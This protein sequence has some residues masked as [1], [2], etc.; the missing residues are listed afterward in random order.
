MKRW[1]VAFLALLLCVVCLQGCLPNNSGAAQSPGTTTTPTAPPEYPVSVEGIT[2][3]QTP[4]RVVVMTPAIADAVKDLGFTA[5]VCGMPDD[6]IT[7]DWHNVTELG[8]RYTL[9]LERL[10]ALRPD[11]ILTQSPTTELTAWA[12]ENKVPLLCLAAPTDKSGLQTFYTAIATALGGKE[13]GPPLANDL[14]WQVQNALSQVSIVLPVTEEP[15]KVLYMAEKEAVATG[16]TVWQYVWDALG[17]EN[18]AVSGEN[19]QIPE[20]MQEPD[21]VFCPADMV[22]TAEKAWR[23]ADVLPLDVNLALHSGYTL[24]E[25]AKLMAQ[26]LYPDAFKSEEITASTSA[27]ATTSTTTT[28]TTTAE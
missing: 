9:N 16:D 5:K 23:H 13:S 14:T 20:D 28:T 15:L 11:L 26:T 18:T 1:S 7:E 10:V 19:W 17:W 8:D 25:T 12:T 4:A 6:C 3:T 24:S 2:L 21:V 27:S 22:K